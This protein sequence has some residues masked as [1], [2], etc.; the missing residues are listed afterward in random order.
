MSSASYD[1][2]GA[3]READDE[4]L[5]SKTSETAGESSLLV[6][7]QRRRWQRRLDES[8]LA[9]RLCQRLALDEDAGPAVDDA[10]AQLVGHRLDV[11]HQLL[12]LGARLQ[13]HAVDAELE[14]GRLDD[15]QADVRL[16]ARLVSATLGAASMPD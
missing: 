14:Q 2:S 12:V 1:T 7:R 3:V 6:R 15:R 4:H 5:Q 11:R 13:P 16:Q 8:E 10:A 9:L